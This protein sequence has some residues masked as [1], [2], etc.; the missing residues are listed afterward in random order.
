MRLLSAG[1][2]K[3]AYCAALLNEPAS[4]TFTKSVKSA[5]FKA[6]APVLLRRF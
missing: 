3:P 4:A 2:D 5:A 1:V 6:L